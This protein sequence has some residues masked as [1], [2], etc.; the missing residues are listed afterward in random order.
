LER[1]NIQPRGEVELRLGCNKRSPFLF[2]V[3]D[4]GFQISIAADMRTHTITACERITYELMEIVERGEEWIGFP[5]GRE[6][7][8]PKLQ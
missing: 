4:P 3:N 2:S 5:V 6:Q 1:W 7:N 8:R